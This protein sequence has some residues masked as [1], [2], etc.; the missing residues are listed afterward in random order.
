MSML[1]ETPS[2]Q[3]H[4]WNIVTFDGSG[5]HVD[6]TWDDPLG[7]SDTL[8]Y[9]YFLLSDE[10]LDTLGTHKPEGEY[11]NLCGKSYRKSHPDWAA[12]FNN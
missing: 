9:D 11:M 5:Y 6:V 2:W 8:R 3:S 4:A 10:E 1:G 12:E 7:T